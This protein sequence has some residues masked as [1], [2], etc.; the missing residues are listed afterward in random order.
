MADY[1]WDEVRL[2]EQCPVCVGRGRDRYGRCERC[3][4]A[5][6]VP[7]DWDLEENDARQE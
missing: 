3:D 1:R 2:T 6:T 4:G 5:G 7:V